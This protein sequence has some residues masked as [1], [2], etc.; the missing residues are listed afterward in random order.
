MYRSRSLIMTNDGLELVFNTEVSSFIHPPAK[1]SFV[2]SFH[3]AIMLQRETSRSWWQHHYD[4][5]RSKITAESAPWLTLGLLITV[6]LQ[7][8]KLPTVSMKRLLSFSEKR[9]S[10]SQLLWLC[11]K[12]S[13][14]GLATPCVRAV[15]YQWQ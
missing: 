6:T 15:L 10:F 4:E 14:L 13:L 12:A 3:V 11:L 9:P 5:D 8:V 7:Q 1:L 2:F